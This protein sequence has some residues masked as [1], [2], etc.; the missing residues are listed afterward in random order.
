MREEKLKRIRRLV[1]A[2]TKEQLRYVDCFVGG[3]IGLFTPVG[4]ACFYAL[5]PE[6]SHPSYMFVLHFDD[7]TAIK[8]NGKIIMSRHGKIF[9]L[10]PGIKHQELPSDLP[11][12]YIAILIDKSF[13]EEQLFLY[14]VEKDTLRGTFY[15]ATSDLLP[16]LKR[17]MIEADNKMPGS[18]AVLYALSTEIAHSLIRSIYDFKPKYDRISGRVEIDR[19]IDYLH[20]NSGSRITV[21]DIARAA[22]M[23]PSHFSH[24][25]KSEVGE[26]PLNYLNRIRMARVKKLLLARDKSITEISLE[27][28][29]GSPSYLSA[30]FY[31]KFKI[32]PSDFQHVVKKGS[33]SKKFRRMS[34]A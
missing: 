9:A 2:A 3:H 17:F 19:A 33:I 8:L 5:T 4:G 14:S 34:K 11:P 21:A 15:D 30:R 27:C 25:F 16:I 28:G 18:E 12:R 1:G 6:H 22:C 23:S 10:S 29:F 7:Q 31:K 13:F 24:V 20:S 32:S 26:S